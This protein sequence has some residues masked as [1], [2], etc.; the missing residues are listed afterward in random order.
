MESGRNRR[1]VSSN[2]INDIDKLIRAQGL[3]DVRCLDKNSSPFCGAMLR[4]AKLLIRYKLLI[5]AVCSGSVLDRVDVDI[6]RY[7][8]FIHL[9][10]DRL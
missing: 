2:D 4:L 3:L 9:E 1:V 10:A 7:N 8:T 5:E 6:V